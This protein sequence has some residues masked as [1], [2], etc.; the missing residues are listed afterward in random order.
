MAVINTGLVEKGIRREYDERFAQADA[1]AAYQLPATRLPSTSDREKYRWLGSAPMPRPW[2]TGRVAKGLRS[3]SY[4]VVN[5]KYETT[6]EV[7]RDEIADDQLGAIKFRI[8]ELAVRAASHKDYL[9]AQL[10]IN[11]ATSGFNSYDGVTFFNAAHVSGDSGSQGND[12]DPEAA[13]P[14]TPTVAEFKAALSAAIAAMLSFKDDVGYPLSMGATGLVI[15]TSPSMYLM[16]LE[17]LVTTI[18]GTVNPLA[19]AAK[20]LAFPWLSAA[21]MWYLCKTDGG[22]RPF[23]WQD[24]EAMEF[25]A[26]AEGSEE[27]FKR[28]KYL[29]SVR[30]RHA[31]TYGRWEYAVHNVFDSPT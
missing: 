13:V 2:G 21:T 5:E 27:E 11:G 16:A 22:I 29:Y 7:D 4:D 26:L 10:L 31:M 12:L 30:G 14:E 28:E 1:N 25:K 17:S 24:R 18:A 3:E 9:I 23:V 15:V 20:V 8:N 19:N 6:I